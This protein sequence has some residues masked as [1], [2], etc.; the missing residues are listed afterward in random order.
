MSVTRKNVVGTWRLISASFQPETGSVFH[1]F[2]K[3]PVGQLTFTADGFV[4]VTLMR[5]NKLP[6][7]VIPAEVTSEEFKA[8][9]DGFISSAGR[10]SVDDKASTITHHFLMSSIPS[11]VDRDHRRHFRMVGRQLVET[12][13]PIR[14]M[15]STI[16]GTLVWEQY[17]V[18][19]KRRAPARRRAL[20]KTP[21]RRRK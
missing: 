7:S 2:G 19:A 18:A 13:E 15:Q 3:D 5:R 12:T 10:Y 20:K 21:S 16:V 17:P 4:S 8:A 11:W 14:T 6:G 1:P 9:L